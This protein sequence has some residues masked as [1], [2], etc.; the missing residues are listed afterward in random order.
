M[1]ISFDECE[2][3]ALFD[4]KGNIIKYYGLLIFGVDVSNQYFTTQLS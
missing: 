3:A 2:F 1:V 4:E